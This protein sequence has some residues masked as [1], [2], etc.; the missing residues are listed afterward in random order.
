ML[1]L[2]ATTSPPSWTSAPRS[3]PVRLSPIMATFL[4]KD[5]GLL[6]NLDTFYQTIVYQTIVMDVARLPR[7]SIK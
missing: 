2:T 7:T 4:R 6:A 3:A 5:P 1:W